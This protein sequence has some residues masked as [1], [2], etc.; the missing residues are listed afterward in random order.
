MPV[1]RGGCAWCGGAWLEL[2]LCVPPGVGCWVRVGGACGGVLAG[3]MR[4]FF[5]LSGVVF[6]ALRSACSGG[7][8]RLWGCRCGCLDRLSGVGSVLLRGPP[9]GWAYCVGACPPHGGACCVGV[10]PSPPWWGVLHWLVVPLLVGRAVLVRAP[11]TV[12]RAVL[13]RAPRPLW[14]VLC[15]RAA[16]R[17]VVRAAL[18]RGPPHGGACCAGAWPSSWCCVGAC[19]TRW[20]CVVWWCLA[21]V[22][23]VGAAWGPALGSVGGACGGVLAGAM[24]RFVCSVLSPPPY[25]R[26]VGVGA[27]GG[28][29]AVVVVL[30]AWPGWVLC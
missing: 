11:L 10:C 8:G 24:P 14:G 2:S 25:G 28:W 18:L 4:G 3:A 5:R 21:W 30:I 12:G 15:W 27:V 13:V 1:R 9:H 22:V 7:C 19:P 20:L 6:A 29:V 26:R 16:C 23:V 17:M